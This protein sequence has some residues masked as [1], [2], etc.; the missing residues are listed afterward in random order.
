MAV[1]T[2]EIE[3]E[4]ALLL[5]S[6]VGVAAV[7]ISELPV[8]YFFPLLKDSAHL[9]LNSS[10]V[11]FCEL[12]EVQQPSFTVPHFLPPLVQTGS[13]SADIISSLLLASVEVAN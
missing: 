8:E 9:Q 4:T 13:V 6:L 10:M 2:F 3:V 11:P 7:I 5:A 12:Q 1:L